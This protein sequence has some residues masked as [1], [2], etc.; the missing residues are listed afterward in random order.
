M[1]YHFSKEAGYSA[2]ILKFE[3]LLE[4]FERASQEKVSESLRIGN[5]VD[6]VPH[7]VRQHL[8][9]NM[10]EN[11]RCEDWK[12]YLL[13]YEGAERWIQPTTTDLE[14]LEVIMVVKLPWT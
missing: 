13:R 8:L 14:K 4:E 5:L 12:T 6:G 9:L 11:T 3:E 7:H 2:N 10:D 1:N